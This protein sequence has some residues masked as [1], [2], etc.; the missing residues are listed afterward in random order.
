MKVNKED[1][2]VFIKIDSFDSL[3]PYKP[4]SSFFGN[5]FDINKIVV[6]TEKNPNKK[7]ISSE[8]HLKQRQKAYK[9]FNNNISS[10][11]DE[12]KKLPENFDFPVLTEKIEIEEEMIDEKA[13]EFIRFINKREIKINSSDVLDYDLGF[14]QS[15]TVFSVFKDETED[16]FIPEISSPTN[17]NN[18]TINNNNITNQTNVENKNINEINQTLKTKVE[19]TWE[20]IIESKV[21]SKTDE[22]T[23]NFYNST[24]VKNNIENTIVNSF[25]LEQKIDNIV[26]QKTENTQINQQSVFI[27]EINNTIFTATKTVEKNIETKLETVIKEVQKQQKFDKDEIL[28]DLRKTLQQEKEEQKTLQKQNKQFVDKSIKD[29]LRS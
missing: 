2:E 3:L 14:A 20:K 10:L 11:Y 21:E 17:V 8:S 7:I 5:T 23:K 26:N 4:G 6:G 18:T 29:F 1:F 28:T 24:Q 25:T 13:L 16:D 19:K 9:K 15:T 22:I 12:F 27:N